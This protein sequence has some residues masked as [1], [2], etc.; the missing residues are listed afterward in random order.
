MDTTPITKEVVVNDIHGTLV[1]HAL[2]THLCTPLD[3]L[4][5]AHRLEDDLG[6]DPLDLVLIMLDLEQRLGA[7]FPIARLENARTVGDI[8]RLVGQWMGARR[9]H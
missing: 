7:E 1:R 6:L 8:V 3:A 4:V 5:D 2:A 9:V